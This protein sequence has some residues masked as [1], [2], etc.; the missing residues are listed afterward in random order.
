[1]WSVPFVALEPLNFGANLVM[2]LTKSQEHQ[3]KR[4]AGEAEICPR[5]PPRGSGKQVVKKRARAGISQ[6]T[7]SKI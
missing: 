3:S 5:V 7:G 1:M 2:K 6:A 4:A